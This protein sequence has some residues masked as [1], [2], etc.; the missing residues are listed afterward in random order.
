[1]AS[2]EFIIKIIS[3]EIVEEKF[4][5]E[6]KAGIADYLKII[7][8][9]KSKEAEIKE[10]LKQA[11]VSKK[12]LEKRV[13][14]ELQ[15][16]GYYYAINKYTKDFNYTLPGAQLRAKVLQKKDVGEPEDFDSYTLYIYKI[17]LIVFYWEEQA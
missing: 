6:T 12:D 5:T 8:K 11:G 14:E 3:N 15:K 4:S 2:S 1:M 16:I 10:A 17:K 13:D 9:Y 7:E